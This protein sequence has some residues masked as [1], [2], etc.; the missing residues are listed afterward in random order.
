[1]FALH[2]PKGKDISSMLEKVCVNCRKPLSVFL[3]GRSL[4]TFLF[5]FVF[6]FLIFH[7]PTC[8][9]LSS[10]SIHHNQTTEGAAAERERL[11]LA[12][13]RP[14]GP[15]PVSS[16]APHLETPAGPAASLQPSSS[17]TTAVPWRALSIHTTHTHAGKYTSIYIFAYFNTSHTRTHQCTTHACTEMHRHGYLHVTSQY[18]RAHTHTTTHPPT[19][20]HTHTHTH[21]QASMHLT[22]THTHTHPNAHL[23]TQFTDTHIKLKHYANLQ[24]AAEDGTLLGLMPKSLSFL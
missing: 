17:T 2:C 19:H 4:A 13:I 22:D 21:T 7:N 23:H 9:P 12:H 6:F 3:S 1:M 15:R 24:P 18:V 10:L 16:V 5:S 8:P 11:W 20:T 14:E